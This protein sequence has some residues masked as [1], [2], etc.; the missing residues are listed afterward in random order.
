MLVSAQLD[1]MGRPVVALG[2]FNEV[3]AALPKDISFPGQGLEFALE[4]LV[5]KSKYGVLANML[6]A[7]VTR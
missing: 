5:R 7:Y 3:V 4:R 1:H 2:S 6:S